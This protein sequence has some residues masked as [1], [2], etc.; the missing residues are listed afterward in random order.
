[1][2]K[3]VGAIL[4]CLTLVLTSIPAFGLNVETDDTP[5]GVFAPGEIIVKFKPGVAGNEIAQVHARYGLSVLSSNGNIGFQRLGIPQGRSVAEMADVLNRN[6]HVEYAEPNYIFHTC[7]VPNDPYYSYQWHLH[8]LDEGGI[9]MEPA[10]DITTGSG[11]IVAVVDTGISQA[12]EDLTG[13]SFVS[14]YDFVNGDNDP[15]DDNGH[16]THCAGTVAQ[17]TNNNVGVCGVAFG[18]SLMPVKVLDSGGSGSI[19]DIADG[20][21]W[22]TDQ[23]ANII[24]LSLGGGTPTS[25]LENAVA[26]AYNNGVTVIAASGNDGRNGVSYPAAYD[27]YVIAVGATRYDTARAP[28]SNYGSSLDVVAPGGDLNVDQSGDTYG[29]GV[30]QETFSGTSW[31]YYFFE[32]TSM[33]TP[34]VSGTAALLYSQ[35]VTSPDEIRNVLQSSAVDLGATGWDMYYGHGLINAYNALTYGSGNSPPTADF[36]YTTTDLT[37]DFIDQSSDSDGTISSWSWGFGDGGTSTVQNPS[38]TYSSD[39]TYTVTLTVTDDDG[40]TDTTTQDVTVSSGITIDMHVQDVTVWLAGTAGPWEHIGVEATVVDSSNNPIGGV[41]VD[42]QL[43]TPG[44]STVTGTATTDSSGVASIV[45]EKASR[46][47]GVYTGTVIGL[48]KSGYSWDNAADVETSDT[49][50]SSGGGTTNNP[51]TADFAYTT[52]E[53]TATFTDQSS[54]SDGSISSWS[55]DFGDS[56]TSTVQNP[57]HTY[58]SDGTYTVTLTVTDDDGA[59]DTTTQDVTV[60]S[61]GTGGTDMWVSGISWRTKQAGPNTFLY[62]TVTVM[63]D[64]GPVSSATVQSTL[65]GPDG[66]WSFSGA[67]DSNGEIEFSLKGASS[68]IYTAEVTGITHSSYTYNPDKDVDNPSS[69][70]V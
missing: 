65:T 67:T 56:A 31:G 62:Y 50:D 63:S 11:A 37:V 4:V 68:G 25:T 60:S 22:A 39:G 48:T 54:D 38:H 2:K 17:S 20:I 57:S 14:G 58:S 44:G 28:Y 49:Y 41:T 23:G 40:A 12:G 8:G 30:L 70:T 46:T 16:G 7:M 21:I 24:S 66:S 19:Y 13:T 69:Y 34:H 5:G 32:G 47:S 52:S 1:M 18:A 51:P 42:M 36:T 9:N 61:G 55:W 33:A 53:L 43:E 45:F 64:E 59:T 26:Y 35:G 6:P 27:V 29:D 10:W 15:T 3:I